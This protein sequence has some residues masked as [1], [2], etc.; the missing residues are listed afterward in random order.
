MN[1]HVWMQI[2]HVPALCASVVHRCE[3]EDLY[4]CIYVY[5]HMCVCN[6]HVLTEIFTY[7]HSTRI[8][9]YAYVHMCV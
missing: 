2:Q 4:I 8:D 5:M 1:T 7:M 3:L 6:L 9:G